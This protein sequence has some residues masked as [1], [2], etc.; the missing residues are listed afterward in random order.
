ME[1]EETKKLRAAIYI[2]VSTE[3]QVEKYGIDLQRSSILSL[4]EAR[5]STNPSLVLAGDEYVYVDEGTSG[6]TEPED[7]PAF[8][9]LKDD[10]LNYGEGRPF[11]TVIVF[12]I[13]RFA[14][15]LRILL[16][17]TDFLKERG[18][19][20][21]SV[22][23]QIDTSSAFGKAM[24]GILGVIAE[25]ELETI[26]ARTRLG[27]IEAAKKGIFMG[28]YPP[29]GYKKDPET[30]K[31][32]IDKEEAEMIRRIFRLFVF[33]RLGTEK[34]ASL[35]RAE[36]ML[37]PASSRNIRGKADK[38]PSR[39]TSPSFW[40]SETIADILSNDKYIG[41]LRIN[42]Y[43]KG[44][45]KA[46][47]EKQTV[48]ANCIPPIVDEPT[49]EAA[50]SLLLDKSFERKNRKATDH[51]YLLSHLLRCQSCSG[52]NGH[53]MRWI[54]ERRR[55]GSKFLYY[56]QCGNK[57]VGKT[58]IRCKTLPLPA[59]E[60]ERYVLDQ[61]LKM[62]ADPEAA[63]EYQASLSSTKNEGKN[64]QKEIAHYEKLIAGVPNQIG[65]LRAQHN[66]GVLSDD[67]LVAEVNS[68]RQHERENKRRLEGLKRAY[69]QTNLSE[70]YISALGEFSKKYG[71]V[72]E[73]LYRPEK[74]E[75]ARDIVRAL[76]EEIVIVSR[77]V[78]K[79]DIVAGRKRDDQQIPYRLLIR[80]RLPQE[81]I[82]KILPK[83][84]IEEVIDAKTPGGPLK[85]P[86][87]GVKSHSGGDGGS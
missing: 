82:Q 79:S 2:R 3:E 70:G 55:D 8:G 32:V 23:E 24:L 45:R 39:K 72:L 44:G 68:I 56:Y 57:K 1:N 41:T 33:Q 31:L 19:S 73:S 71:N 30:K 9:R 75:L 76:V 69:A 58:E 20:F 78:A 37:S 43:G 12:K 26:I 85:G 84:V 86:S 34:I 47:P 60:L 5:K 80:F 83:P 11:D 16:D 17:I 66:V 22:N 64:I 65:H 51:I 6:E 18:V 14:R 7:R 49:F 15:R 52:L 29:Y 81:I 50:Q 48:I 13:D 42:K 53:M 54:G 77:P 87:S 40:R 25:F 35:L 61:C 36:K 38:A 10:I 27:R 46:N 28:P 62:L 74:R 4:I 21:I 67:E 59:A 63:Y